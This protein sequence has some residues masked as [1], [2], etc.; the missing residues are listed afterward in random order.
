MEEEYCYLAAT[1]DSMQWQFACSHLMLLEIQSCLFTCPL[2][3][4]SFSFKFSSLLLF[5]RPFLFFYPFFFSPRLISFF[6]FFFY[7]VLTLLIFIF[8][9]TF[10][11][12]ED[13][14]EVKEGKKKDSLL[15]LG[16]VWSYLAVSGRV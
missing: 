16:G 12:E 15:C 8:F 1:L 13:I 4:F 5:I 14:E 2:Y 7:L 3:P 11:L 9:S 6:M 10:L